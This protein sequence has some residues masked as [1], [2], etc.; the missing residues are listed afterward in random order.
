MRILTRKRPQADSRPGSAAP[1]AFEELVSAHLD[2]L[3]RTACRLCTGNAADAEDLLQDSILRALKHYPELR[4]TG[5]AKTWLFTILIRTNLNRLRTQ[6]RRAEKLAS[7]FDER[8]FESALEAWRPAEALDD[9]MERLE[10]RD[11][12]TRSLDDLDDSLR[13][14][15][16][17]TDVEGFKQRELAEIL[18]L[19]EGTVGSRLFRAR[20]EL[21]KALSDHA[22]AAR[23]RG[24]I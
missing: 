15:V 20:R 23:E 13:E 21:R 5:A 1:K 6:R 10:L 14:I 12:L 2:A 9:R 24:V 11:R 16:W 7:D 22:G 19:P 17:L 4:S 18:G 3:Y 8:E